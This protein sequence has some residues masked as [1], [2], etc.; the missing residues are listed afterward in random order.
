MSPLR[1][2]RLE[3]KRKRVL[4]HSEFK[5]E[6]GASWDARLLLEFNELQDCVHNGWLIPDHYYRLGI[7]QTPDLL[8]K[9]TGV[10]HL[11]L[12]GSGSNTLVYLLELSDKVIFLRI[13]GHAYLEDDPRGSL[14]R[15]ALQGRL[16]RPEG[17]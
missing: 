11:H 3:T 10:K 16:P 14:L 6:L 4:F 1:G 15:R 9:K 5:D 8:L 7:G 2:E 17:R 12:G 13:A